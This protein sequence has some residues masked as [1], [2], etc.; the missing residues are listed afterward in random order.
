MRWSACR[1]RSRTPGS[2][3]WS[4]PCG[5]WRILRPRSCWLASTTCGSRTGCPR[6]LLSRGP[7]LAPRS[8]E[9]PDRRQVPAHRPR[10]RQMTPRSCSGGGSNG[11]SPPRCGGRH[12]FSWEPR[13]LG[14]LEN[15]VIIGAHCACRAPLTPGVSSKSVGGWGIGFPTVPCGSSVDRLYLACSPPLSHTGSTL[16]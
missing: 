16:A 9:W 14:A 1:P 2:R 12:S 6:P 5:R 11:I 3:E 8:D 7:A 10:R 13:L 4:D 15:A